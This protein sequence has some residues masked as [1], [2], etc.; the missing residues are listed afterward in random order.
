MARSRRP[1]VMADAAYEILTRPARDCTG[2]TLLAEDVLREAGI[3]DFSRY[4]YG[5]TSEQ[6]LQ[7]DLFL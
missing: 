1:E 7:A 5:D 2:N 3:E 6:D 4:R